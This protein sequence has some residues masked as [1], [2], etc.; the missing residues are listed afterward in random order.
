MSK[1]NWIFLL[2]AML[3]VVGF[4]AGCAP[5][6]EEP[7]VSDGMEEEADDLFSIYAIFSTPA[8]EPWVSVIT[9]ACEKLVE[10]GRAT[11]DYSDNLGYAGD[12]ER[13]L[14]QVC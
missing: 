4:A 2:L 14:R 1:R 3:M 6:A 9:A 11:F 8:E 7:E 13:E 12:F 10:E 5:P